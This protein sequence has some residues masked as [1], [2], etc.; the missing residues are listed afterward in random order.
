MLFIQY[1]TILDSE[2]M[3]PDSNTGT[4]VNDFPFKK[5]IGVPWWGSDQNF[6]GQNLMVPLQG[7]WA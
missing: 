2:Y 4:L 1:V 6:S 5:Y 3:Y 7:A